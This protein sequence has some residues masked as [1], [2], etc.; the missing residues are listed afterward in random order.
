MSKRLTLKSSQVG[1][2]PHRSG[3]AGITRARMQLALSLLTDPALDVL[4]TGESDFEDLPAVMA[5][6]AE[7]P[8]D[9]LCQ[10]IRYWSKA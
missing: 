4:I 5:R 2:W 3:P 9:A 7:A 10:R 6:L 8:G 1:T